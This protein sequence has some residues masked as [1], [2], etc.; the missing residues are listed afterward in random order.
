MKQKTTAACLALGLLVTWLPA[1]ALAKAPT[2][3]SMS[4]EPARIVPARI[5]PGRSAVPF[6]KPGYI[7]KQVWVGSSPALGGYLKTVIE[8]APETKQ[9][10]VKQKAPEAKQKAP[11]VK[12]SPGTLQ[13]VWVGGPPWLGGYEI[14]K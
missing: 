1:V 4:K 8:K 10:T 3:R 6:V 2:P 7:V 14:W 12:Q 5:V 13:R 11:E 9:K